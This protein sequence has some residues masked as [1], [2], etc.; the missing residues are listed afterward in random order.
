MLKSGIIHGITG[1]IH[2]Y[3]VEPSV[4]D[5]FLEEFIRG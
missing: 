5:F 3:K 1:I 4:W 2:I